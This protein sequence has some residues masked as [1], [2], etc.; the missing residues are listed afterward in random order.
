MGLFCFCCECAQMTEIENRNRKASR[1]LF[2]FSIKWTG[3]ALF[4]FLTDAL[5]GYKADTTG[6][7]KRQWRWCHF[8]SLNLS[9][10]SGRMYVTPYDLK[11]QSLWWLYSGRKRK[12]VTLWCHKM[13][14]RDDI[15]APERSGPWP[16]SQNPHRIDKNSFSVLRITVSLIGT[17]QE[18]CSILV[19]W[20]SSC[21]ALL[22]H[23]LRVAFHNM[24]MSNITFNCESEV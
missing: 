4:C 23:Q 24:L 6:F 12:T 17:V 13:G 16:V 19:F 20:S 8:L 14:L 5:M 2:L 1:F 21:F 7:D 9:F 3:S 10:V 22:C 15:N 11:E 18:S